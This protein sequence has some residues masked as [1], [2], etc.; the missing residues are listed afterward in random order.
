MANLQRARWDDSV[1]QCFGD[2]KATLER[3]GEPISDF[4]IAIAAHAV[5]HHAMLVTSNLRHMDRIPGLAVEDW[6][7]E[8]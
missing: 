3:R 5:V 2:L 1:S 6:S 7:L 4:D 8:G